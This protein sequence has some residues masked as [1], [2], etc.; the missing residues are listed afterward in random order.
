MTEA[1][2]EDIPVSPV[3]VNHDDTT[4]E[5][6]D[7][8]EEA[9]EE[10]RKVKLAASPY[11]PTA[12][13]VDEHNVTHLPFRSWCH[14]CVKGKA[15]NKSHFKN[16]EAKDYKVRHVVV[17]YAFL[18]DKNDEETVVNQVARDIW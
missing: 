1:P 9:E 5:L 10:A 6:E 8:A 7:E 18:G 12:K 4:I 2:S 15:R 14:Q 3:E 11:V 17:D 13:E 16:K